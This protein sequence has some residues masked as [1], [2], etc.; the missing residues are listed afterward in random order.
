MARYLAFPKATLEEAGLDLSM[1]SKS[2]SG[3]ANSCEL[4]MT[5]DLEKDDI[6]CFE[7]CDHAFCKGRLT[8][9]KCQLF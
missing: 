8:L 6:V 3:V 1:L 5:D 2:K 7:T 4:C 9:E